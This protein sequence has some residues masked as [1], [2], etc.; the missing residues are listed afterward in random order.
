MLIPESTE[1]QLLDDISKVFCVCIFRD[2]LPLLDSAFPFTSWLVS[3]STIDTLAYRTHLNMIIRDC[4][5][6]VG[7]GV[8]FGDF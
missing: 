6:G 2:S 4:L 7:L 5:L 1:Y 3:L 8:S